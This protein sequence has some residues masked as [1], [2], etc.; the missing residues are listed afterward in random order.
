MTTLELRSQ[1]LQD[2]GSEQDNVI[3]EKVQKYYRKLKNAKGSNMPCQYTLEELKERLARG[4]EEAENGGGTSHEE[5]MKEVET[6][7]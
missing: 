5:F 7:F 2:I 3:L 6:W 4:R 1:I